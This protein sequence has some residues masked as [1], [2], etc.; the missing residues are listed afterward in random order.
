M[1]GDEVE[2]EREDTEEGDAATRAATAGSICAASVA[3]A[4][5][6]R[7]AGQYLMGGKSVPLR[8]RRF[9]DCHASLFA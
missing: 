1:A 4:A 8:A 2:K 3:T 7:T 6:G 9:S 5:A